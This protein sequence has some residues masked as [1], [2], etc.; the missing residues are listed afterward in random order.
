VP[1]IAELRPL[2][3]SRVE[4]RAH[5]KATPDSRAI[6]CGYNGCLLKYAWGRNA[7]QA[8][9]TQSKLMTR[10]PFTHN[11]P[12]IEKPDHGRGQETV[13]CAGY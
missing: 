8:V 7:S 4:I 10:L 1:V 5:D 11:P 13:P 12:P 9:L 2:G 6:P 3:N